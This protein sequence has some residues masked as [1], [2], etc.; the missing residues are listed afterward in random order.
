[1]SDVSTVSAVSDRQK[2][3]SL[4]CN[5]LADYFITNTMNYV[6][7]R[8]LLGVIWTLLLKY[9]V[10]DISVFFVMSVSIIIQPHTY[11]CIV[12]ESD[13]RSDTLVFIQCDGASPCSPVRPLS[14]AAAALSTV[15]VP[16][17]TTQEVNISLLRPF[18]CFLIIDIGRKLTAVF[19]T[20][21]S[22]TKF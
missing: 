1:M 19:M 20:Y 17:N 21:S 8:R 11:K 14:A 15:L 12:M 16:K 3:R 4:R 6:T 5:K 7:D 13:F 18:D 10:V 9:D 2:W 22:M